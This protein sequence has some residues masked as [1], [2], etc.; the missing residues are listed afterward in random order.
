VASL[1]SVDRSSP[2][3]PGAGASAGEAA[4]S[5]APMTLRRCSSRSRRTRGSAS[6]RC[7]CRST[8]V[9]IGLAR[10]PPTR[11]ADVLPRPWRWR[12]NDDALWPLATSGKG[13][14]ARSACVADRSRSRN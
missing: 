13:R 5:L 3:W 8:L 14:L 10:L 11:R 1:P 7:A 2:S 9:R 12:F 4:W 6:M